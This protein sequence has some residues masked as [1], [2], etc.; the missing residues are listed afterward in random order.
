MRHEIKLPGLDGANPLGFLAALGTL[1]TLSESKAYGTV[2]MFWQAAGTWVP[3]IATDTPCTEETLV[4]TLLTALSAGEGLEPFTLGEDLNVSPEVFR[5]YALS[6]CQRST[7]SSRRAVDFV[8]AF[9]CDGVAEENV[10][11][12]C[13]LRTMSGAG[14][15]HFLGFMRQLMQTTTREHLRTALLAR[16]S[17]EDDGPSMRWDPEDDRRYAL[18]WK[19]PSRDKVQTVRG[20]NCLAVQGLSLLSSV[21]TGHGLRTTGFSGLRVRNTFWSWPIWVLPIA[22]DAVR[23]LLAYPSL[24]APSPNAAHLSRLGVAQVFRSQR[25]T[26]GKFRNFAPARAV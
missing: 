18:R 26:V 13:E 3:V 14:H 15:Q 2:K 21:P 5:A 1:R 12:D 19:E 4:E 8:A 20:A 16:W 24:A 6:V 23:S 11:K 17:Y 9:G 10:I 25:L 7:A 22:M